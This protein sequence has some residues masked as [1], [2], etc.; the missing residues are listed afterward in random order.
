MNGKH[1]NEKHMEKKKTD[2]NKIIMKIGLLLIAAAL[3]LAGFN[4]WRQ[5]V[6]GRASDDILDQIDIIDEGWQDPPAY[7]LNPDMEMPVR[8]INGQE[9]V[10]VIEIPAADIKLPVINTWSYPH[11]RVAPCRFLG[12]AYKNDMV[13]IG[14]N[15]RTHFGPIRGLSPGAEVSFTDMDGNRFDYELVDMEIL[16]PVMVKELK[17]GD[18]D[19][20]LVTCTQ[21]NLT[22][23]ALRCDLTGEGH[24]PASAGGK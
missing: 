17:A 7:K 4:V 24:A 14:H 16:E 19:L 6:A 18:W 23:T 3:V 22:R 21:G 9:I 10:G 12:T 15:F 5:Y 11:L 2:N 13:I 8:I 20:T 1:M